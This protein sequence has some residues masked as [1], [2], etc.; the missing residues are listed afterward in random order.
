MPR[1]LAALM[2]LLYSFFSQSQG[3]SYM[4]STS[5]AVC[6]PKRISR[7]KVFKGFAALGK[8]TKGWFL[9]LKLHIIINE[10]GGLMRIKLTPGNVDD[11]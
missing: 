11:H 2:V 8:T 10:K 9:G 7:N 5:L 3:I 1:I 4:D 6:H